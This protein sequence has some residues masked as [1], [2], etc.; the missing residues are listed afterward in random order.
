MQE[1]TL[2][3]R[4]DSSAAPSLAT[5]LE[6]LRGHPLAI[7]ASA[8]DFVGTLS[9]EVIVAAGLQWAADGHG[10]SVIRPSPRFAAACGVLGLAPASPWTAETELPA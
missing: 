3:Q 4:L 8:V 9:I 7:D 6:R 10:L 2:P 5:A 1:F